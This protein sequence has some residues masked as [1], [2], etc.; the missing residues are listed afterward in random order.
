MTKL[1]ASVRT[2][3]SMGLVTKVIG[4]TI[5]STVA[6]LKFG[7]TLRVMTESTFADSN[8]VRAYFLGR[9]ARATLVTS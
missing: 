1:A 2:F 3:I 4:S 7:L 9:M 6:E 8:K 5:G